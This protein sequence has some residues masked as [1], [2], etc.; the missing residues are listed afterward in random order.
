MSSSSASGG[1]NSNWSSVSE[2][3]LLLHEDLLQLVDHI[4][5]PDQLE[6]SQTGFTGLPTLDGKTPAELSLIIQR[7]CGCQTVTFISLLNYR[8]NA[9]RKIWNYL[10][11]KEKSSSGGGANTT[12]LKPAAKGGE[13]FAS[14][15]SLVLIFPILHSLSK[16]DS[17]LS[18]ETTRILLQSLSSCDPASLS[19]EPLDCILGLE[20]LLSSWLTAAREK[21][22]EG[23]EQ[24]RTAASALVA[25]A[26]AVGTGGLLL[27]TVHTLQLLVSSHPGI[28]LSLSVVLRKLFKEH[29]NFEE[30][31]V[32]LADSHT[33]TSWEYQYQDETNENGEDETHPRSIVYDGRYVLVSSVGGKK[34]LKV[35]SG[36]SGSIRGYLYQSVSIDPGWLVQCNGVLLYRKKSFDESS[37]THLCVRLS[38]DLHESGIVSH[39]LSLEEGYSTVGFMSDGHKLYWIYALK[40]ESNSTTGTAGDKY[41]VYLQILD[42]NVDIN[43]SMELLPSCE[44]ILLKKSKEEK[45]RMRL[46]GSSYFS[47]G[48]GGRT[49]DDTETSCGLSMKQL[50]KSSGYCTGSSLVLILASPPSSSGGSRSLFGS[51]S[52]NNNKALC[53]SY[54]YSISSGYLV[55]QFDLTQ[56]PSLTCGLTRGTTTGSM[57]A[58]YDRFNHCVW[59]VAGDWVDLWACTGQVRPSA[60]SLAARMGLTPSHLQLLEDKE[61]DDIIVE[62]V[63]TL[64]LRHS[65][66]ESCRLTRGKDIGQPIAHN[67]SLSFLKHTVTILKYTVDMDQL[68]NALSCVITLQ[69]VLPNFLKSD[70]YESKENDKLF[71][72]IRSCCWDLL[73]KESC[74]SVLVNEICQLIS[75]N[76]LRLYLQEEHQ[77]QLLLSALA[78]SSSKMIHLRNSVFIELSKELRPLSSVPP[79]LLS[80]TGLLAGLL[81]E[82]LNLGMN[83]L[84]EG[85]AKVAMTTQPVFSPAVQCA[86]SI[87]YSI[88]RSMDKA[89][90][91]ADTDGNKE[92]ELEDSRR[93]LIKFIEE[94]QLFEICGRFLDGL[95]SVISTISAP[96]SSTDESPSR[97]LLVSALEKVSK[98]SVLGAFLPPLLAVISDHTYSSLPLATRLLPCVTELG[99]KTAECCSMLYSDMKG[100]VTIPTPW[101]SGRLIET[102]HP[103]RDNYKFKETVSFPRAKHLYLKFDPRSSSQ[104]D[105]DKVQ[106][107]AGSSPSCPKVVE[108]GGNTHGFGSRSVLG[109]GWPKDIVKV[110]GDTVTITFEMKSGR[111]HST[112]DKAMWGFSCIVR[113][114]ETAEE[115][116]GGLPF[117]IDIYLSLSS[118]SCSLIGQLFVGAPP[119]SDEIKCGSLM[120][121]LLLQRCVW[122]DTEVVEGGFRH[123]PTDPSLIVKLRESINKPRPVLRPRIS[124]I[125]QVELMEDLILNTCLKHNENKSIFK[126][127]SS[128][129][130]ET[131]KILLDDI[132][133]R[134]NGLERRL[135]ALAELE[136]HWCSDVDDIINNEKD[137]KTAFFFDLQQ[138]ESTVKQFELLC[139]L[140][141]VDIVDPFG[142]ATQLQEL[143]EKDVLRRKDKK[144]VETDIHS[145]T[146]SLVQGILDRSR[147]LLQ[148]NISQEEEGEGH[149]SGVSRSVSVPASHLVTSPTVISRQSS[150]GSSLLFDNFTSINNNNNNEEI[151]RFIGHKPEEA[152][153]CDS[154]LLA[155]S[156]QRKR[157]ADRISSL[158][159]LHSLLTGPQLPSTITHLLSMVGDIIKNGPLVQDI[160]CSG[161]CNEVRSKFSDVILLIVQETLSHPAAFI[162]TISTLSIIPYTRE[163]EGLLVRTGLLKVLNELCNM[164]TPPV[165][166]AESEGDEEMLQRVTA[167]AWAAFKVLADRCISWEELGN[168]RSLGF[169]SSGLAQQISSL[170]TNHFSRA[171]ETLKNSESGT[172]ETLQE[173]L[174]M[175]L[176]LASSHMGRAILSQPACVSKLLLLVT[177]QR[178]SPKL[179]LI[180]LQLCRIALPLMTVAECSQVIIPSHPAL[181]N[182]SHSPNGHASIIIKL[183]MV[184]LGEYLIPTHSPGGALQTDSAHQEREGGDNDPIPLMA[185][186][187]QDEI[188]EAGQASVY[189]YRRSD[190]TAAEVLQLLLNQ[191]PRQLAHRMETILRLDQALTDNNKA[192]ILTDNY[193]SCFRKAVR[194]ASMGFTVS[195]EPTTNGT[196]H[197]PSGTE[198]DRKRSKAETTCKKKNMEL[199]KSDPPR[200]FLSG[201]V[202][203]SLASEIIGLLNGLLVG[204]DAV[205]VWRNAIEDVLREALRSVPLSL[206]QLEDYC[207]LVHDCVNKC[208]T[209]PSPQPHLP[210]ASIA[211]ACFAALG[212]FKDP[213]RVGSLVKVLG[214]GI[215]DSTGS[216]A[217]ISEQRG[218]A[219]VI[220]N[221]RHCFG[222]NRTLEV[223][224]TRLVPPEVSSLPIKQLGVSSDLCLAINSV[225]STSPVTIDSPHSGMNP[226][227]MGLGLVRLYSE[228]RARACLCLA[229]Q[230]RESDEFKKLFIS[231]NNDDNLSQL[232]RHVET[233]KPG[234]RLSVVESQCLS[235]R[236]LYRDCSR[237]P[238]PK[239]ERPRIERKRFFLDITRQWPPVTHSSFSHNLTWLVYQGPTTSGGGG[240]DADR[241]DKPKGVFIVTNN[242]IPN[243]APSFYYEVEVVQ[244][245][246]GTSS[247]HLSFGLCPS[248]EKPS[249]NEG[250]WSYPQETCLFRNSGR[251]F[252]VRGVDRM[253]WPKISTEYLVKNGDIVGCGWIKEDTPPARGVVYFTVNGNKLEQSFK[254]CPSGLYPFVHVQKK[255][256]RLKLNFGEYSFSYAEGQDHRDAADIDKGES[257]EEIV[258]LFKLLPFHPIDEEEELEGV[259]RDNVD[260]EVPND[261]TD[262]VKHTPLI[263]VPNTVVLEPVT[264]EVYD[265]KSSQG[266]I[267]RL[268]FDNILEGGPLIRPGGVA[269]QEEEELEEGGAVEGVAGDEDLHLLLVKAW[270]AKVFPLIQRRFRNDQERKSG[271]DQIRGALQLGMES[272]AQETVEFL[273]EENGGLPRDLHLPSMDDV[274][275]DLEKFT[276]N[277]IKKG[278]AVV[279]QKE[280]PYTRCGVRAMQKTQ[281]L[282]GVVLSVDS[283]NEL[284]QVECYVPSDGALVRFWYPVIY[285]EKPPKGYRKPSA[286]RGADSVSILVHRELLNNE[287]TLA[288]LYCRSALLSLQSVSQSLSFPLYISLY[289]QENYSQPSVEGLSV[290]S[291]PS[292]SPSLSHSLLSS[293]QP[294]FYS[295]PALVER[296]L[297]SWLRDHSVDVQ[298]LLVR[299]SE[300]VSGSSGGNGRAEF[301]VPEGRETTDVY[302][303]GAAF[304][305]VSSSHVKPGNKINSNYKYPWCKVFTYRSGQGRGGR[306]LP[307]EV[308]RYPNEI[309][310]QTVNQQYSGPLYPTLV[311]PS[312]RLHIKLIGSTPHPG[313][314]ILVHSVPTAVPLL[315]SLSHSLSL[316]FDSSN[317]NDPRYLSSCVQPLVKLLAKSDWPLVMRGRINHT[318]S[319]VL[320]TLSDSVTDHTHLP[321]LPSDLLPSLLQEVE[322][323]YTEECDSFTNGSSSTS[324]GNGGT[325][326]S[327]D[328]KS[329]G[330]PFPPSGSIASGR[331]GRFSCYLQS[332]LELVLAL[333]QYN[334][335]LVQT[336]PTNGAS[337]SG[338]KKF[339]KFHWIDYVSRAVDVLFALRGKKELN[340]DFYKCFYKSLPSKCHTSLL[341]LTGINSALQGEV[342]M[343]TI[344]RV[345]SGYGGL[346]DLYL[347]LRDMSREEREEEQRIKLEELA[348][349][350]T[351]QQATPVTTPTSSDEAVSDTAERPEPA[352]KKNSLQGERPKLLASPASLE[353]PKQV[354]VGGAVLRIGCGHK[355]SGLCTSLLSC[356]ALQGNKKRLSVYCVSEGFQCGEEESANEI[357]RKYLRN[358]LYNGDGVSFTSDL[359]SCLSVVFNSLG[360]QVLQTSLTGNGATES[361]LRLFI[362]GCGSGHTLKEAV[363]QLW[364]SKS[365]DSSISEADL[366][367]WTE[368]QEPVHIWKGLTAAGYDLD[369]NRCGFLP[370]EGVSSCPPDSALDSALALHVDS[371]CRS[372]DIISSLLLPSE[373]H[374]SDAELTAGHLVPLQKLSINEIR[375][376]FIALKNINRQLSWLLPLVNLNSTHPSSLGCLLTRAASYMFYDV[377]NTFLH[378]VLNAATRRTLDQAPPEIKMDPLE[379]VG[380]LPSTLLKTQFCQAANQMLSVPSSQLCVPLASGGDPTYAF[381]VKL[382]GEEVHGT[383]GSFRHFLWQVVR[384]LESP[385]VPV[386]IQCP[387]S[388]S[389]INKGKFILSTGSMSYS[390]E[391]LLFFFGQLLGVSLR[392]DVPVALD[393]LVCF[394]K[395]LK[396]EPL[397]LVDLKEA[398]SVTYSLT[399]E[400]LEAK[401]ETS[402]NEIISSLCQD[403][404]THTAGTDTHAVGT[405]TTHTTGTDTHTA[406]LTFTYRNLRGDQ[407]PLEKDGDH[408][409]VTFDNRGEYVDKVR[410]FRLREIESVDRMRAVRCGLSSVVPMEALTVFTATDLDLRICGIPHVDINYLKMHT[411]YHVGLMESDRHIQYFW[412]AL[413]SLSQ[414]IMIR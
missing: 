397:S 279:I 87:L 248:P 185:P 109:K 186:S 250:A 134:I 332:I 29:D 65:G 93:L 45:N 376:R 154:F 111:E 391:K 343:E 150:D 140:Y 302:C 356:L 61:N 41:N 95:H 122:P 23:T 265:S 19:K 22:T 295:D 132:F 53:T 319:N 407:E 181:S 166:V 395:S 59:S 235:L 90:A 130:S 5:L 277:R 189:L 94:I 139:C 14:R 144:D 361:L 107:F 323:W 374:V 158:S 327:D 182:A 324:N 340:P 92:E 390:E 266:F 164:D 217:S 353:P 11:S 25:L 129:I 47:G 236:M 163:D 335:G 106:V 413:E 245:D 214:E 24:I 354:P 256:T 403:T 52:T 359:S 170:L 88:L 328:G 118:I 18:G 115:S 269:N 16:I 223:P 388:A 385:L 89:A 141:S 300:G 168:G 371:K 237:P 26:V 8:H 40:N 255:G 260:N 178:P 3:S 401:D 404:D 205:Q 199:L 17:E 339:K 225:L 20:N 80:L 212:G 176:G 30:P 293:H 152:V 252:Q 133:T 317:K 49:K 329:K 224:L 281:G 2:E 86:S 261:E 160:L 311:V 334:G 64:L 171:M 381:N 183:L 392:A 91:A 406:S 200:P 6:T 127:M 298:P 34:L 110:D 162:N 349:E 193:K 13:G 43:D 175:L 50:V 368:R 187:Q 380:G 210:S 119:T 405:D 203:Y 204:E 77:S 79:S 159:S 197:E 172:S 350:S 272:I 207:S 100:P 10:R 57:G 44:R 352:E 48:S 215:A 370:L 62:D 373:L 396:E 344:R 411:T 69:A 314:K 38:E 254:D 284:V 231:N 12:S 297:L 155:A 211:N 142:A 124:D 105:Y 229:A 283:L 15:I 27:R 196:N 131:D 241:Q 99:R 135:Q 240:A 97:S 102:V 126:F 7:E 398:D 372:L 234:Q 76:I 39:S 309:P 409:L 399:Q 402:F 208:E 227:T 325:G 174:S 230:C 242:P 32:V 82:E 357:L 285:L 307:Q 218:V 74:S 103:V 4:P 136:S 375:M 351:N 70:I 206:P 137:M 345:C 382:S 288:G 366:V 246:S 98:G 125:L 355:S 219:N 394:W 365:K 303:P 146:R 202:S 165:G 286:L 305:I 1:D 177:D 161:L 157:A 316:H 113:P 410:S 331:S 228:L 201:T 377:K 145:K 276:I 308:S 190:E 299:L 221:D 112:P 84:K 315:L 51:T 72:T 310:Q 312:D 243:H 282:T 262:S 9:L 337:K 81:H 116:S 68:D 156:H 364:E 28:S 253:Q 104:Y 414:V 198:A 220:L 128:K 31:P 326:S 270:E 232:R 360:P 60:H 257:L 55:S 400:I 192:E 259:A 184:K 179:V 188:D 268:S 291:S 358:K 278:S 273:Y 71:D 338:S 271:L 123:T 151:F 367:Q 195:I 379:S 73:H 386:L 267:P 280:V 264:N 342:A 78:S 348:K 226:G 249:D 296:E 96:A 333:R 347:P 322:Q 369:F 153:S 233:I 287:G 114:Q 362:V 121:S 304:L 275:A 408:K 209:P 21:R 148:V 56:S 120:E 63:I 75:S 138:Q 194:W 294:Q 66:M 54:G 341:V 384:E 33:H 393:L 213:L 290:S 244:L 180:A 173:A 292:L 313:Q 85:G 378:C 387:S 389:G 321:L 301:L 289:S 320:W 363:A 274:K 216:V 37:S 251:G 336:T 101:S 167:L 191:D 149:S 35:G 147:L 83:L 42:I 412:T 58:S 143:M 238:P 117:L 383:S 222:V 169:I 263:L 330:A 239:I 67:L 108:Y 318:L 258:A 46:T 306:L 247:P 346:V 36:Y